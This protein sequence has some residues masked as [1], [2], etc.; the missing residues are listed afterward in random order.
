MSEVRI[1]Y[2]VLNSPSS[3]GNGGALLPWPKGRGTTLRALTVRVRIP[4]EVRQ[5]HRRPKLCALGWFGIHCHWG[6]A[7]AFPFPSLLRGAAAS[8]N[9][10]I[11]T[12]RDAGFY[13]AK[14]RF[15][16]CRG[17]TTFPA[18]PALLKPHPTDLTLPTHTDM[19]C[20][21]CRVSP[22]NPFQA[23]ATPT[24]RSPPVPSRSR[25]TTSAQSRQS[26]P[27]L[28][29]PFDLP[30]RSRPVLTYQAMSAPT[31]T[32]L[33]DPHRLSTTRA[34]PSLVDASVA[35]RIAHLF[36]EQKVAGSNPVRG[37][38]RTKPLHT[39]LDV[40]FPPLPLPNL[41]LR[42]STDRAPPS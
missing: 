17:Y 42:S 24:Y 23:I 28:A 8:L 5:D 12:D 22:D 11:S 15:E 25:H 34:Q 38:R 9:P 10:R 37:A 39:S 20:L 36:P 41:C 14:C 21:P 40:P 35:Q 18:Y 31:P 13:P 27:P 29:S 3:P 2:G 16:S 32:C 1:L 33:P 30:C 19:P 26:A 7:A 6:G 4:A